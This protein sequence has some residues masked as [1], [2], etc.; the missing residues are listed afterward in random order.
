VF[1]SVRDEGTG[2]LTETLYTDLEALGIKTNLRSK[3]RYSYYAV[4]SPEG[5][6]ENSNPDQTVSLEGHISGV[7][8]SIMSGGWYAGSGSSIV[9]NGTE[10]SKNLRGMNI[11]IVKDEAVLETVSFDTCSQE[12]EETR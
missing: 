6:W 5:I 3:Y 11:V 8:F 2:A 10:Y 7:S 12:M 9:I 4:I 1:L